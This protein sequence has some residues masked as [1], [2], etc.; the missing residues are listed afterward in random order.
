[1]PED[2]QQWGAH[3]PVLGRELIDVSHVPQRTKCG[4]DHER[5]IPIGKSPYDS[6]Q[7]LQGASPIRH[8]AI[9]RSRLHLLN[10]ALLQ[11][12]E[13]FVRLAPSGALATAPD[14]RCPAGQRSGIRRVPVVSSRPARSS[15]P[16]RQGTGGAHPYPL[17]PR[18]PA[19]GRRTRT[20]RRPRP[21]PRLRT[22]LVEP[23]G[24]LRRGRVLPA[25][26][27]DPRDRRYPPH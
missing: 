14:L 2:V 8:P 17:R 25:A 13:T 16:N 23:S 22:P 21:Q 24:L 7:F 11:H 19:G 12:Q 5:L 3:P 9:E 10:D 27:H 20:G 1:M 4:R 6:V 18:R 26:G 15:Q